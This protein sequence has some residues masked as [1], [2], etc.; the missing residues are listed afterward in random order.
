MKIEIPN[1]TPLTV[2]KWRSLHWAKANRRKTADRQMI[3]VYCYKSGLTKA[4]KKRR[5]ELNIIK[6]GRG[7]LPD[8]DAY[9][10]SVLD[11]L[12]NLGYIIDDSAKW[13]EWNQPKIERGKQ[14]KTII[15]ITDCD[16]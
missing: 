8:P 1:W 16:E 10:K 6:S 13:V 9:F 7:R 5:V 12:K 15:E 3:G 14:I 4:T 2:N 11:A